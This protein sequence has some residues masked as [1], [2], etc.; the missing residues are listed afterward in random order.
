MTCFN[1]I[2]TFIPLWDTSHFIY[3]HDRSYTMADPLNWLLLGELIVVVIVASAFLFY[4]NRLIG[5]VLAFFI[6][7]YTWRKHQA[8]IE[9]GSLQ[10]S[11]LAGRISFR[12]VEYHSSNLSFRALHG[13][14]TFR[15]WW[16]RVKQ[17]G[18]SQNVN[19]KRRKP[20]Y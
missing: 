18:D 7:L 15:Y 6:R 13:H 11:P 12:D 5:S 9:I 14:V 17:E 2:S 19:S 8:Y 20:F 1:H 4:F 3:L 16:A 10:I